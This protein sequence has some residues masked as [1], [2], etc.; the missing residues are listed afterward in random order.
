MAA[1]LD[2]DSIIANFFM[3]EMTTGIAAVVWQGASE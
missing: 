3:S 1:S 2:A